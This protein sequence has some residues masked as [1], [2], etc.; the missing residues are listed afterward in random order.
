MS[1]G[2]GLANFVFTWIAWSLV[3]RKA[4]GLP[5]FFHFEMQF[6]EFLTRDVGTC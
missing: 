6:A 5:F 2:F 3:D 1:L 4:G